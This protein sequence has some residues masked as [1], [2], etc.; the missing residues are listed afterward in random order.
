M[1]IC[2]YP[3][4]KGLCWDCERRYRVY[5]TSGAAHKLQDYLCG[6][7]KTSTDNV[8]VIWYIGNPIDQMVIDSVCLYLCLYI[9]QLLS[10]KLSHWMYHLCGFLFI[11]GKR[12][13]A[14]APRGGGPLRL[15]LKLQWL[16][17]WPLLLMEVWLLCMVLEEEEGH[18]C[19]GHKHPCMG[20]VCVICLLF[21]ACYEIMKLARIF[22]QCHQ[23][24]MS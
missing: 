19:M 2:L 3:V 14:W 16:E 1:L 11:V 17:V 23:T 10:S 13:E 20:M 9:L 7:D 15:G 22:S 6:Q 8:S 12:G 4:L 21:F 5:C 24:N 18:Q